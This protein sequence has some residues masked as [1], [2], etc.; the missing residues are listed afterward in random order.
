[1]CRFIADVRSDE[2]SKIAKS[3]THVPI[4]FA[5]QGNRIMVHVGVKEDGSVLV[6]QDGQFVWSNPR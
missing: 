6:W 5:D 2:R 3:L 1:M 4:Q